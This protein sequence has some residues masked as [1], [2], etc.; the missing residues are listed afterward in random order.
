MKKKANLKSNLDAIYNHFISKGKFGPA[1]EDLLKLEEEHGNSDVIS[2]YLGV[3]Y[4]NSNDYERAI[5]YLREINDSAELSLIQLIQTNML[6]GYIYTELGEYSKAEK[7]FKKALEINPESSMSFSAL[8]YVYY[9]SKKYDLAIFN[10]KKAIQFDPNN[11]SAHNNLGYTYLEL[12]INLTEAL[13]E[14]RKA[15]ALNPKSAAYRDSLGWAYF[16]NENYREAVKELELAL[17]YTT[18]NQE[19]I[20]SHLEQAIKKR[21]RKK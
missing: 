21:D 14:C 12:G 4:A 17:H 9:L 20:Y 1:I 5:H 11:A 6:L 19:I 2:Y 13:T 16:N 3:C 18:R 7:S 8:G 10:F 15:V